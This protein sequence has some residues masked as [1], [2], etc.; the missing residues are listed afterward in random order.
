M[1]EIRR[2]GPP[3][4]PLI[5]PVEPVFTGN[6][7]KGFTPGEPVPMPEKIKLREG[8]RKR[9]WVPATGSVYGKGAKLEGDWKMLTQEE[10]EELGLKWEE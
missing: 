6:K 5:P 3:E 10:A 9:I 4:R 8:E 7:N 2:P 1:S